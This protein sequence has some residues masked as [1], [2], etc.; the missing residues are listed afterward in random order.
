MA[1]GTPLLRST[2]SSARPEQALRA[3]CLLPA[4]TLNANK[5]HLEEGTLMMHP[6]VVET[7]AWRDHT[8]HCGVNDLR[9]ARAGV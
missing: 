1:S 3:C 8:R 2:D 5:S 7:E 6:G 4:T 9:S